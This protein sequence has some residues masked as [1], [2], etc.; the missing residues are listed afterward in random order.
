MS[1]ED[2]KAMREVRSDEEYII[3][4]RDLDKLQG[5]CDTWRMNFIPSK[6]HIF[7]PKGRPIV[8]QKVRKITKNRIICKSAHGLYP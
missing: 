4:Q 5:W 7:M 3:L 2:V 8:P 6:G 1:V